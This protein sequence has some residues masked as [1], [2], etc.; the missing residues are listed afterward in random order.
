M[1]RTRQAAALRLKEA[2]ILVLPTAR[3][4]LTALGSLHLASVN[5]APEALEEAGPKKAVSGQRGGDFF[6]RAGIPLARSHECANADEAVVA[7]KALGYPVVLKA[8][9]P[10]LDHKSEAGG[11]VTGVNSDADV[12]AVVDRI[13]RNLA[14]KSP[15]TVL[16]G[17][18]VQEQIGDGVEIIVGCSRDPEF[19]AVVM[20]G[21]GGI[22]AE[23]TG[24]VGFCT[25]PASQSEIRAV[26]DRLKISA[27]LK[28]ARGRPPADI[29]A[30]VAVIEGFAAA[31][32]NS[33][34]VVEAELNPLIV[35]PQPLGAV[36][37]DTLV[38]GAA[39]RSAS[40]SRNT[41]SKEKVA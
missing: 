9:A 12:R 1:R 29:D 7:G 5:L 15:D 22:F 36:A 37:V 34:E 38:V 40:S 13:A 2:G 41:P 21:A 28:G 10:G 6:T 24:D 35:R 27:V 4:L 20:I 32:A 30:A 11:V 33:P 18:T 16:Q 19:G 26:I 31:F 39:S 17:F 23:I 3:R 8:V 14:E 25:A